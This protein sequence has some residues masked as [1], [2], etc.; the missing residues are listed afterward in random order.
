MRVGDFAS[1]YRQFEP[2]PIRAGL[3]PSRIAWH[4]LISLPLPT[5]YSLE[6]GQ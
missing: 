1:G 4:S 5:L 3:Y 6:P 2:Q